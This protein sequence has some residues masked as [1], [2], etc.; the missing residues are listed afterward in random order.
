MCAKYQIIGMFKFYHDDL[1]RLKI[2]HFGDF[3]EFF[4]KNLHQIFEAKN[5]LQET[6]T[7]AIFCCTSIEDIKEL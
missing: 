6:I 4:N 2:G 1:V 3:F 7:G 5:D